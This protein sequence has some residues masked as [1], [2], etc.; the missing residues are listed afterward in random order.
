M[1]LRRASSGVRSRRRGSRARWLIPGIS[2]VLLAGA[3]AWFVW[4]PLPRG[5]DEGPPPRT[6]VMDERVRLARDSGAPLQLRW[7][8]VPLER[9]S[10]HLVRT[11]LV[12]EDDRFR[13]HRGVD[14]RAL[15]EELGWA[16]GDTFRWTD[17]GDLRELA[18]VLSLG[19]GRRDELRGRS[20]IT[21]QLARNLYLG[22]DRS[23][24]R[25]GREFVVAARL[26]RSLGK[27]RILELYLNVAEW[28][29]GVFGAEAAALHYFGVG[30]SDLTLDQAAAL[31][32]TLP[33]PLTSNPHQS[34]ARM[35]WRQSLLLER[36]GAGVDEVEVRSGE[37]PTTRDP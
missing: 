32:A 24:P 37:P 36:L 23:L 17:P 31:A 27:D 20:T 35:R 3:W 26:E 8:W 16:R 14:W 19:W 28:G 25:K 10:P 22:T 29:P 33:H 4:I 15:A 12:A 30:A 9:I 34:P 21:Q 5:L 18:R 1:T 2:L 7:E 13:E 11:V 6:A